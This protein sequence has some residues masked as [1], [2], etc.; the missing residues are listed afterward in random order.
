[1]EH[2]KTISRFVVRRTAYQAQKST[3]PLL[4]KLLFLTFAWG[5]AP[6]LASADTIPGL[7]DIMDTGNPVSITVTGG[8]NS[9]NDTCTAAK[10]LGS[11]TVDSGPPEKFTFSIPVDGNSAGSGIVVLLDPSGMVSDLLEVTWVQ[12]MRGMGIIYQ[13]ISGTFTSTDDPAGLNLAFLGLTDDVM[14]KLVQ[15]GLTETGLLQNIGN[16]LIDPATGNPV[17]ILNMTIRA[18]SPVPGPVVGAGLPGLVAACGGLI[19]WWRRRRKIA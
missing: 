3:L 2:A 9:V 18:A 8:V 5:L 6:G 10:P 7:V 15:N 14:K 12:K 1:M 19:A 11:C 4:L 17:A 16:Q 13:D